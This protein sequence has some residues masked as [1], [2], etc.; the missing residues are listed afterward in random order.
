MTIRT[1]P[2]RTN[3][4]RVTGYNGDGTVKVL[5]T[6]YT[7]DAD[8]AEQ[9]ETAGIATTATFGTVVGHLFNCAY[10]GDYVQTRVTDDAVYVDKPCEFSD[11]ITTTIRLNVPSG[12]I[13]INDDLR[14]VYDGYDDTHRKFA[15][16]TSDL[17]VAQVI[18]EFAKQ[19][20]AFGFVGDAWPDLFQTGEGEYVLANCGWDEELDGPRTPEGWTRLAGVD[21]AIWSYSIADF[22]DWVARGGDV[23]N[24][25]EDAEIVRIPTGTYEFTYHGGERGF[26]RHAAGTVIFT[27]IKKVA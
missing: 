1:L 12:K 17:G 24:L 5:F 18:E 23:K 15:D 14:P 13:V 6:E 4:H 20:C 8:Q 16:Y 10:C 2:I 25:D 22:G 19:G 21:G 26:D 3:G 9:A 7:I 27:H 11:G